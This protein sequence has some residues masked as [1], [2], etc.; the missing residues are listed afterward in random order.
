M[1]EI[2]DVTRNVPGGTMT[3]VSDDYYVFTTTDG[4]SECLEG[5]TEFLDAAWEMAGLIEEFRENQWI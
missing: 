4:R 2:K 3:K 5:V 1:T